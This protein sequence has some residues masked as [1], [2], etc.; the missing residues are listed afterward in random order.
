MKLTYSFP[1][2]PL[3]IDPS[4]EEISNQETIAEEE[5]ISGLLA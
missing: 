3:E 1:D 4:A 5:F 2:I